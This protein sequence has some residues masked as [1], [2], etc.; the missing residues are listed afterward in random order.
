MSKKR[1]IWLLFRAHVLRD[2]ESLHDIAAYYAWAHKEGLLP[3][4]YYDRALRWYAR[5]AKHGNPACLYD[6]GFAL[7]I[8][9]SEATDKSRGIKMI[10]LAAEA[11]YLAAIDFMADYPQS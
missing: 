11:G 9:G 5:G 6:Y 7:V 4:K 3:K 10:K 2:W 8:E 1:Q